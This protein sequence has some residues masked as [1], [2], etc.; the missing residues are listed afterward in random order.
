MTMS[1]SL[2]WLGNRIEQAL[3]WLLR[4]VLLL[5]LIEALLGGQVL[6][7]LALGGVLAVHTAVHWAAPR[8]QVSAW[9]PWGMA[10]TDIILMGLAYYV[11][12][13]TSGLGMLLWL[14]LTV[15]VAIRLT[16]WPALAVNAGVWFLFA[17]PLIRSWL[18]Q[19]Q[20]LSP[21]LF[22]GL[23]LSPLLTLGTRR[24][25]TQE[26]GQV[27]A[28]EDLS[29]D[30]S[31][32]R[33]QQLATVEEMIPVG[34]TGET[35]QQRRQESRRVQM[36]AAISEVSQEI[37]SRL[38]LERTLNLILY[39]VKDLVDYF[40]AEICLWDEARGVMVTWGA[41]G[42]PRYP[43]GP[44]DV[45]QLDEGYTGWIARHKRMLFIP[46]TAAHPDV[47]PKIITKDMPVRAYIG[48]PLL[49]RDAFVGTLEL[50]SDQPGT[51]TEDDVEILQ[52]FASQAAVAIQNARLYEEAQRHLNELSG[53][54]QISQAIGSLTDVH[55]IYAQITERIAHL[56]GM[57]MC[58]LLLHEV[59]E[60]A[61]VS[62]PPFYG[63]PDELAGLYRM[64]VPEGST[65]WHLWQEQ[66]YLLLNGVEGEPL[67]DEMGLRSLAQAS[68]WRHTLF[69]PMIVG[70]RRIG[71]IQVTNK[72]NGTPLTEDDARLL[73]TFASQ[74]AAVVENARLFETQQA[75]LQELGILFET[76]TAISSSLELGEVLS[77]VARHMAYA[78]EVSS[79]S[80]SD[81]D[82]AR[83]V[84]TTLVAEAA[85]PS[86][87]AGLTTGDI[88]VSYP[89]ADYP[90]TEQVLREGRPLV[91]QAADPEA[92]P[93]ERALLERLEQQSLLLMALVTHDRVVGLLELYESRYAR[94]FSAE[95]I[96][97]CRALANQAAVA[98]DNARLYGQTDERLRARVD[99]LTALQRTT[100]EL[101]ATLERDR[102]LQVVLASAVQTA[103]AIHG[104]VMVLD[105]ESGGFVLH[106]AHGYSAEERAA[107]QE[108]LLRLGGD[109]LIL[110]VAASGQASLVDDAA[111]QPYRIDVRSDSSSALVVPIFYQD[112]VV[113][114][115]NLTHPKLG[116]FDRE[117]LTFVQALAEQA[118][119]AVGNATR[120]EEQVRVNS[121]LR[122]RTDQ[123]AGLLA[124]SQ[125]LRTDVPL[126]DTLEEIAYAIQ[127]TVGFDIVMIS[128]VDDPKGA[129]PMLR[130]VAAAG[131]PL[132]SFEEAKRV[133]QPLAL[134]QHLLREEYRRGLCYFFPFQREEDWDADLHT[135]VPMPETE[136]WHEG[137]WHPHDMLVAPM[138]GAGG[139]LLGHISVDE[140][141]DGLR[142]SPSALEVLAIFANQAAI[143]VENAQ[144]YVDVHRRAENLDLI[145]QVGRTLT[146]LVE[147][148][149]VLDTVVKAVGLL[150]RCE[151]GTIYQP[152]PVDGKFVPVASYGVSLPALSG[153]RFAPGEGL[154]GRVAK[155]RSTLV[156]PN[157]DLEPRYVPGPTP[158]GSMMLVP[159]TVGR[160]LTGV[161][162][163]GSP[164]QY[165]FTEADQVL[166]T[167]LADQA[168]VAL[169]STR[170]LSNTQQAALR[171]AS[172]NEIG[173]RVAAHLNLQDMLETTVDSLHQY[174]GYSRVGVFLVD[175][176]KSE[177]Y[178]AA[179]NEDFRSMIPSGY[180]Q[181]L[182]KGLI[183]AAA[184]TGRT[185]LTNDALSD[186][187]HLEIGSWIA[188]ASISVPIKV[189]G[190]VIG[191][192]Q[193]EADRAGAFAEDDASAL[194]I[195]ADQ[196]AVAME[197][198]RLFQQTQRRLA[199]LATVNEIGRAISSALDTD[200]LAELIYSHV[201]SLL[202]A[203]TFHI[204]L[205]DPATD[206]IHVE[207]SIVRGQRQPPLL[208][209]MGQGLIS[210]LVRKG[211][212]LL[213]SHGTEDSKA[214]W[215]TPEGELAKSW[216][217]VPMIAGDRAIGAIT[218]EDFDREDAFDAGHMELLTI[219]AGQAAVAY[220]NASLFQER[221]RRIEQL[222][223]L[224]QTAE[225]ITSTLDLDEL[226]E[227]VYQQVSRIADTTNFYIALYNDEKDELVFP[228]VVDPE[229]R[230]EW[231][232]RAKGEG[233]TGVIIESGRPLLLPAGVAGLYQETGRDVQ[234][235]M[236]RSWLGVPMVAGDRVLGVIAVQSY[237]REY[238]YNE[239]HLNL[240]STVAA[241]AAV[242]VRN[243][244]LY[245][246]IVRFSG[247][248]ETMVESRTR[249]LEKALGELT[250]EHERVETLYRI[251]RELGA[252]LE[253]DRVLQ[254]AL[255]LF[256]DALGLDHGTILLVDPERGDLK[257]KATLDPDSKLP[258]KG[259]L[260]RWQRG[261]GLAGWVVEHRESV[262]VDDIREDPRWVSR[263]GREMDIRSVIVA[264]LSLGGGDI[265]GVLTLGHPQAGYFTSEHLQLVTAAAAQIAMAVN[266]S[267]LYAFITDQADQLGAALQAQLEEAAKNRAIL[268]S[269]ADGV[270]VLDHNGTV[271]LVNPAAEELLGFVA[272]ALEGEHAR[273]MLGLGKTPIHRDLAESL[274]AELRQRLELGGQAA[275]IPAGSVRLEAGTRV[276]A[277]TITPLII[278]LGG[279]PGLVAA[280]RD[281]S[282]E[283]EVE[284]LKNEFISTV[285][286]E[287]RTP[288]TS[289]KGYTDLL[290][291]GMAGGLTDAQRNFL[292]I[293]KSNADRLTA[294]VN[295]ILDIS[296]IET[297][298][299][300]L[301]IES[302]H[303]GQI[304]HQVVVSFEEQYREKGT[305]LTWQDPGPLPE[306]RGDAAR[307]T[308]VLSNLVANAWQYTPAGG[309]VTISLQ[310]SDGFL[311]VDI[312]DTGIGISSD[313]VSRI[314]DRFYRADHPV[315]RET[316]GTGL[317]LAIVK[318]FV[319]LLG[320]EIWLESEL[321]V[322]STFS[323]TLPL[324]TIVLPERL[325]ELPDDASRR[326]KILVVE[327]DR[328][329]ALL[330]QQQLELEGYQVLWAGTGEDAL[331][332]ARETNP[333]LITL[334]IML[335]DLDGFTVL[336]QMKE[337][338]AC[339]RIP[340]V[341][342][343]VLT[344]TEKGYALGAVDYV[345][346]PF[347]ERVLLEAV[348]KALSF[349]AEL[350]P[351][352]LVVA[353]DDPEARALME[354]AL[355]LHGYEVRSASDGQEAL[356]QVHHF[357]PD[358]VLLD[359]EMPVMDGYEV[360]R[361]L[362]SDEAT[363]QIPIIVITAGPVDAER[364]R[365][366]KL[367]TE[368]A[369]YVTKPLSIEVLVRE[370]KKAI[371]TR[372]S[373][374]RDH[375]LAHDLG[376][377]G[378]RP[379]DG[380]EE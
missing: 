60:Q 127:E 8:V 217:G 20:P 304:V 65:T 336:R 78:L 107:I 79:C 128:V 311:Q 230:E 5:L 236:C 156:I 140:P 143:A 293:I 182:D 12:A 148:Q 163:A 139:R 253:L 90:A 41:A 321:G 254:R 62:Q 82:P 124:V 73:C 227:V 6:R 94:K 175:E 308:Q 284:R 349:R 17:W 320:G 264:P 72:I 31:N 16:M 116:A 361:Q 10:L 61:L 15:L 285:S 138:W 115:I 187:R 362:R 297:G 129:T 266:N 210:D 59:E 342:V 340:V 112:A 18:W 358:L 277:A 241:Q 105:V 231:G 271:L 130:R 376:I 345:V 2:G 318:M 354:Q 13:D 99:E 87:A 38:D 47:P 314:F 69:A 164:R 310:P 114:L 309:Q 88:G 159:I 326:P 212:P 344:D 58:G 274:Y 371:V 165:A 299:M 119:I 91:I 252:S 70:R 333:Q 370:I 211:E 196:L 145:N 360:V 198:A 353:D 46:D 167:T 33:M 23:I 136:E 98:I 256:A 50:A 74:A 295:D 118:A 249:D 325:P 219:I 180:R 288:M 221:Q 104:S 213:L 178:V 160:Q 298:R 351:H 108:Q 226:L 35:A 201:S 317:G 269:I 123:M 120:F 189:A 77:T 3:L 270:L 283:A 141:R 263:P 134:Y 190:K 200:Q 36:L 238:V 101:N 4:A 206:L 173:R 66:P 329:L 225:A 132:E 273:H 171:L 106:V 169:E 126:A 95:D 262:L 100:Q 89:L 135:L 307:V 86:L 348:Q 177:L 194:E 259:K 43:A 247:E 291:L 331:R 144:L 64:P 109:S 22:A 29:P 57:E 84:V 233:L 294:L 48:L 83:N 347:E 346:K 161:L 204:A 352:R 80:I 162:V 251:T 93:A 363:R 203:R 215:T 19:G 202:D 280:L 71:V 81:W 188:P 97:L 150:V 243:A 301:T 367:G 239:D 49:T 179:A 268:E 296:R 332:L 197:N 121:A 300:R 372:P 111:R 14:C 192:L 322:G 209:K 40:G 157:T 355:V 292:K 216:L 103:R 341:I 186:E 67:I 327:D 334:D 137:Q 176:R 53:L 218:V 242:A 39:R 276:L 228:F 373:P 199:E 131:L 183:G 290:F 278:T 337:D 92:D 193:A 30:I 323:F 184:A 330:L 306:V 146:Q 117:D 223:V 42:D 151:L 364:G 154:V 147:P 338:P 350:E 68:G 315:V 319:E 374:R 265:L 214:P 312:A 44:G 96:R 246:Q 153:L 343:S 158:V 9:R 328:D 45:Y 26:S 195:A 32:G 282:R 324:S 181:A 170:L 257:L 1:G 368:V 234:A 76:S 168:A 339:S 110:Q 305:T 359:V 75:Q 102:I 133:R 286:H 379:S 279:A 365:T 142:P 63:V 287:L 28:T 174:L 52:V 34:A 125:K 207:F 366:P 380:E 260:A 25:I 24:L 289:I 21:W 166:L 281:I 267:D 172:L 208:L 237:E 205:H 369:Q 248:L 7:A 316:E 85:A 155:T 302:L 303:L 149:Q 55:Q 240:L 56:M 258:R 356:A 357:R 54:Y 229:Q 375:H 220:Q 235:G 11:A 113:G 191:V 37:L 224:S 261:A 378:S 313:D 152:D 255:R 250:L 244:Q 122:Q 275:S 245:Q 272:E 335:P 27:R 51:F 222:N 377:P 185:I 232:P